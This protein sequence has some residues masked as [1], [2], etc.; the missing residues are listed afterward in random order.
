MTSQETIEERRKRFK[1][2]S[3]YERQALLRKKMKDEGL[4]EGS[5]VKGKGLSS[6]DQHEIWELI[7]VTSCLEQL[8]AKQ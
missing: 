3:S 4:E 8:K 5:G 6:Y 7:Q 2:M 1:A